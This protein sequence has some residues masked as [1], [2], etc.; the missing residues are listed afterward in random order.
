M[1]RLDARLRAVVATTGALVLCACGSA[2]GRAGPQ[3]L[4]LHAGEEYPLTG[5]KVFLSMV[6]LVEDS[7]CASGT[8]CVWA[9]NAAISVR[10]HTA[11]GM[12]TT[13]QLNTN[14]DP[15]NVTAMG[16]EVRLDSLKQ[17]P[18]P[19]VPGASEYVAWVTATPA[20]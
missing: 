15:K 17:A 19:K 7:R 12:A 9:G 16:Y 4:A 5:S 13:Y 20:K 10:V 18:N 8:Q 11:T 6:R 1:T 2:T 14:A 3:T